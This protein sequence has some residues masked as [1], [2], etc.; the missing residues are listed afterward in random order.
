M[1]NRHVV[2][3]KRPSGAVTEQCF[4]L[5]E[6]EV[7]QLRE[8]DVLVRNIYVSCDP[9]MRGQFGGTTSNKSLFDLDAPVPARAV[10]QVVESRHADFAEGDVVW[11]FMAWERFSVVPGGTGL[12]LFDPALG[13]IS[14]AISVLGMP[15][16]TAY[17]GMFDIGSPREGE[18]AYVSAAAGAVGQLA[19]QFARLK[20]AR[21]V[22]SAG[23]EAKVQFLRETLNLDAAFN[24]RTVSSHEAAL[25]EHCPD[26]IDVYF[27]NVGGPVLDAVLERANE[28]ARIAVCGQISQYDEAGPGY[29]IRNFRNVLGKRILIQGFSVRSHMDQF[30]SAQA[31]IAHWLAERNV[32]YTQDI[33][34]GLEQ[35]PGAFVSMMAGGNLGKR[36]VQVDDDPFTN[37]LAG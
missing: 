14:Y 36:L 32:V 21:V 35:L 12:R 30:D 19:A 6:S 15:G 11:G 13:P 8:G 23:S 3:S 29:A 17:V 2:L 16:L 25:A 34:S 33:V 27:D 18:T 9:Y 28:H 1:N 10:G 31:Q 4:A 24:Y 37:P 5:R 7:S 20:G 22:G 26:G